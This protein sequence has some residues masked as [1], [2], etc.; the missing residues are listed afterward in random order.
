MRVSIIIPAYNKATRIET[1]VRSVRQY[2]DEVVVIDDASL[3]STAEMAAWAMARVVRQPVHGGTIA[4]LKRGF[5]EA[6]GD[7]V[8]T[9]DADGEHRAQDVPRL[10]RPILDERAD[11]VLGR[12]SYIACSSERF[13][14]WL[15][16]LRVK[17][18]D[19]GT[20]LRALRRDLAIKLKLPG[21]RIFGVWVLEAAA[22]GARIAEVPIQL[23]HVGK[24]RPIALSDIVQAW[25]LLPWLIKRNV[26]SGDGRD[27]LH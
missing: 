7:V 18:S 1:T 23:R 20:G 2:A 11:L 25:H 21:T 15:T 4:A 12:R 26:T 14:K 27:A 22:L 24:P 5:R 19:S 3:D 13:L 9:M 10:V 8:V 6:Q 17:A 16:S